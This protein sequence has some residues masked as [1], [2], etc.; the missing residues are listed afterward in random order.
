MKNFE[1]DQ[2]GEQI[3]SAEKLS[4]FMKLFRGRDDVYARRWTN[5]KKDR[6]GYS[7]ACAN[8][9]VRGV[10]EKPKVKCGDCDNRDLIPMTEKV[11]LD[12][13]HGRIVAGVYPLLEDKTCWFLA[14]DFDDEGWEEDVRVFLGVAKEQSLVPAIERSRSGKGAHAWIFFQQ[15]VAASLARAMGCHLITLAMSKRDQLG[16]ASY[17]RLF[18]NQDTM[19]KGGFGNLIALPFQGEA[20][21]MGNTLFLDEEL[22]PY[23]DQWGYLNSITPLAPSYVEAL[24]SKARSDGQ[25]I[26]VKTASSGAEDEDQPWERR[27]KRR[28]RQFA[29]ADPLPDTVRAVIA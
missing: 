10:C 22:E 27:S 1:G 21:E 3:T 25:V 18:P 16:M 12:H 7:P 29:I 20:R 14:V 6:S 13:L 11:I 4:L 2:D 17:D 8:E 23:K 24:V 9:W 15:P 26:G 19:P 5:V 28:A